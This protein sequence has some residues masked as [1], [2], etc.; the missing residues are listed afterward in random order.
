MK[1]LKVSSV[2]QFLKAGFSAQFSLQ[3]KSLLQCGQG[4]G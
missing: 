3:I 2:F 1:L 4:G